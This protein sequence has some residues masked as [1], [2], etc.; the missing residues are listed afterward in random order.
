M[1]CV[2]VVLCCADLREEFALGRFGEG[3][4]FKVR[5][6]VSVIVQKDLKPSVCIYYGSHLSLC[7]LNFLTI[8]PDDELD[9]QGENL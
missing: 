8:S 2:R 5:L 1:S 7:A 6:T 4:E 9:F 3:G